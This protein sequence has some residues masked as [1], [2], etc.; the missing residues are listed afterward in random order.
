MIKWINRIFILASGIYGF[1]SL[2]FYSTSFEDKNP[3]FSFSNAKFLYFGV[4]FFAYLLGSIP[5]GYLLTKYIYG[6]DIRFEGSGNIGATNVWRICGPVLGVLTFIL[7]AGKAGFFIF[8]LQK[9]SFFDWILDE[10]RLLCAG[11][12]VFMG[13]IYPVWFNYKGGKGIATLFGMIIAIN[14]L[15]FLLMAFIWGSTF[16][17]ARHS[18]IAGLSA[19]LTPLFYVCVVN[20][21]WVQFWIYLFLFVIVLLRHSLNILSFIKG[22]KR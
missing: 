13:H 1:S 10:N 12:F 20:F 16:L 5:F 4:T 9:G 2:L 7:D 22:K 8:F 18:F 15:L 17:I 19:A 11:V 14:P 3:I 21:E 6:K